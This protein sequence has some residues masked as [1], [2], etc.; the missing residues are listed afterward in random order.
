MKINLAQ[1]GA[2]AW[3]G[4][5]RVSQALTHQSLLKLEEKRFQIR[6][7]WAVSKSRSMAGDAL[8]SARAG[9]S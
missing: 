7:R 4:V 9:R 5:L 1:R 8:A 3:Q 6:V 2:S